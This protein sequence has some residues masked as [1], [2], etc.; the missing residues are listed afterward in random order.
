MLLPH[1]GAVGLKRSL[2]GCCV[3][4]VFQD[5]IFQSDQGLTGLEVWWLYSESK[6]T[7]SLSLQSMCGCVTPSPHVPLTP[8]L[9]VYKGTSPLSPHLSTFAVHC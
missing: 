8:S 5:Q 3:L 7:V 6:L 9:C 2:C 4:M 1:L